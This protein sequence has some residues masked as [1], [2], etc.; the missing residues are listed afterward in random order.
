[1]NNQNFSFLYWL[2][3]QLKK[4]F[5]EAGSQLLVAAR[6]K[7]NSEQF[8]IYESNTTECIFQMVHS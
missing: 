4:N 1:M 7:G 6:A 8:A 2:C 5:A 3:C